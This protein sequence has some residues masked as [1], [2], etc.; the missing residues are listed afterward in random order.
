MSTLVNGQEKLLSPKRPWSQKSARKIIA[1]ITPALIPFLVASILVKSSCLDGKAGFFLG[2]VVTSFLVV[3][4]WPIITRNPN[5]RGDLFLQN[6]IALSA[7]IFLSA[8]TWL[9]ASVITPAV[10]AFQ[11][12]L[13]THDAAV[14]AVDTPLN[15][16]GLLHALA[17]TLVIVGLATL[18][19]VPF[20]ILAALYITEVRGRL[21]PYTRFFIQ[22]MS[23]V[24]SI[25]AGLF[26]Y[27]ALIVT[28]V[29]PFTG[30][31][32][33]LAL[34]ILML[35]TV[36]RTAEEVLRLV[37]DELR[38]AALALGGT[39]LRT[40]F[41]VVLPSAKTGLITAVILGV[42][43]VAGETAPLLLT[44]FGGNTLNLNPFSGTMATLPW[45]IFTQMTLGTD[46]DVA[47][48]WV[49]GLT[50]LVLVSVFFVGARLLGRKGPGRR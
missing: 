40:V 25:V 32:G 35:P 16:G 33:S 43:R 36:A 27:A 46:N 37:P 20:G 50:L 4:V 11:F 14:V 19:S 22:A 17:G 21:V 48:A 31:A 26:I 6:C 23:G 2:W 3:L 38:S 49:A 15:E 28:H 24:P 42:A 34:A 1:E 39:Q 10:K 41:L 30:F 47:R 44:A 45:Y 9:L 29:I 13:L 8:V 18:I 7:V 5:S 12:S